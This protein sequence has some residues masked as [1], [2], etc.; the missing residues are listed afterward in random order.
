MA[1]RILVA[2]DHDV[3]RQGVRALLEGQPGFEVCGEAVDGRQA[4]E[5]ALRL[6]PD[7]VVLDIGMPDMNG[8][9]AARRILE[10]LPATEVLI[11]TMHESDQLIREVV[12][13]GARGY[14]LKSDAGRTLVAAV[15][16]LQEHKP[17]LTSR[18]SE[19][20]LEE[21]RH[22]P[23]PEPA[24]GSG[25]TPRER[26]IVKLIAEGHSGRQVAAILGISAKTVETHRTNV[27]RKLDVHSVTDLVR[28]AIRNNLVT[29]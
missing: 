13:A 26:E 27:M 4:V 2:D 11:L 17:F 6:K 23:P 1:T 10:V 14:V 15:E 5:Q 3:V 18:V 7:L 22:G 29:A 8:L 19:I 9:E 25:L 24:S 16:A 21:Y 12:R 28:Y 20:V